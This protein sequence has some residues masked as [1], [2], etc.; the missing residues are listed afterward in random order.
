MLFYTQARAAGAIPAG[1]SSQLKLEINGL[2]LSGFSPLAR[3]SLGQ[4]RVKI[5]PAGLSGGEPLFTQFFAGDKTTFRWAYVFD[6]YAGGAAHAA[7]AAALASDDEDAAVSTYINIHIYI[8]VC[9]YIYI[10][11]YIYIYSRE[12]AHPSVGRTLSISI[13]GAMRM[14]RWQLRSR[15]TTKTPR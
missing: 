15:Q 7:L 1:G 13:R 3:S 8:C 2:N 10:Y 9:V 5:E 11:I 12:M 6:I 4:L 14:R